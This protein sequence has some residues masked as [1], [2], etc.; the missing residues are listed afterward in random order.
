MPTPAATTHPKAE[1][2]LTLGTF[3]LLYIA[4]SVPMSFFSTALQVMMRQADYSLS[5]IALLQVVKLPWVLKFAW[6]PLVDRHCISVRDYKRTIFTSEGVYAL[7]I[8]AVGFLRIEHDLYLMIALVF[9]SLVASATQD[10]AT[11]ALA[12]LSFRKRDKSLVN[13]MQSMGSFGGTLLGSGLLLMLLHRYGWHIVLPFLCLFVVLAAIP[14]ALNRHISIAPKQ[15]ANRARMADFIYF[16][17]RRSIWPQVGFLIMYYAGI[18]GTLSVLRPWLV[19]LGYST[20]QIGA[21]SMMGTGT[22]FAISFPIG[23]LVRRIGR[24]HAR[25]GFACFTLLTLTY[26][27]LMSWLAQPSTLMLCAGIILLWSSYSMSSVVVYTTAMDIVRPGREGTD[28]TVQTV[29]THGSGILAALV[30]GKIGD[31]AGYHG[32]FAFEVALAAASVLYILIFFRKPASHDTPT[33]E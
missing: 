29:I 17:T 9:L 12:A 16:F 8:L 27:L 10:I 6:S 31:M 21:M 18:I 15:P 7:L 20:S 33:T 22:A 13:S 28:F 32:L 26:F 19:D 24:R 2:A 4:Q 11:D 5:A 1:G 23:L 3:F 25:L 30:S 14:L